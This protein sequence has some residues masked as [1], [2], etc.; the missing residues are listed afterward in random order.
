MPP[1]DLL[2]QHLAIALGL[3]LL[4]GLQREKSHS[5]LAGIRTFP[6]IAVLGCLCGTFAQV[7]GAWV[8]GA[9]M[10][11]VTALLVVGLTALRQEASPQASGMT[12][13]LAA[14]V[15]F[16]VGALPPAG[17]AAAAAVVGA[18]LAIL[19]H[20]KDRLHGWVAALGDHDMGLIMRFAAISL[21]VLPVLP[22]HRYGPPGLEVLNPRTIWLMVV[23]IVGMSVA[24]YVA[25]KVWGS[26]ASTILGG[27]LGGLISSTATTVSWAR[28]A[29][30]D[31]SLSGSASTVVMIASTV[32]F[33]RFIAIAMIAAPSQAVA[34][35]MPLTW[36][37]AVFLVLCVV[38]W[39]TTA[40]HEATVAAHGNPAELTGALVFAGIFAVVL[41][42]VAWAKVNLGQGGLLA[43]AAIS[44]A[45][46]MDAITL[47]TARLVHQGSLNP[48]LAAKA[49]LVAALSNLVFKAGS[50]LFLGPRRMFWLV[51][52]MF[53]IAF[54]A[55]VAILLLY[56][57]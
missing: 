23:L 26:R 44:G 45:T 42:A 37:F 51:A 16:M 24:G 6:L 3:G 49:I 22:D 57:F 25:L 8:F 52:G 50:V 41:L 36:L 12:T 7:Q 15:T 48:G 55:G 17:H 35:A 43:V 53:A 13:A 27:V 31:P 56:P 29:K 19:L 39:A 10:L 1:T 9:G 20:L 34:L 40:K 4:I 21:V 5:G 28:R 11:S 18:G 38:L 30:A 46:D 33:L 2:L 14:L 54:A 32:A 47:G